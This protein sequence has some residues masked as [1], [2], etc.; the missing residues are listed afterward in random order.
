MNY[1]LHHLDM[2][3][4]LMTFGAAH[5]GSPRF[6]RTPLTLCPNFNQYLQHGMSHF[7]KPRSLVS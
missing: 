6:L 1:S 5:K 2:M 3:H 4:Y 7:L